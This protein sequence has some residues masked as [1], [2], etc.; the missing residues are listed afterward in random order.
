M[1]WIEQFWPAAVAF[2]FGQRPQCQ[3]CKRYLELEI[4]FRASMD[5]DTPDLHGFDVCERCLSSFPQ[6][7]QPL[8][9]A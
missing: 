1:E 5:A 8:T 9:F 4:Y 2:R 3:K 7:P 6:V